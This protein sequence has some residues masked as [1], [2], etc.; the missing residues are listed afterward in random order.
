MS[1]VLFQTLV[2]GSNGK[3]LITTPYFLPDK[4]FRA[5]IRRTIARG[6]S[7][8]AIVPGPGTDQHWVRL[9]SRRLYGELLE[10]GMRIFEYSGSM[11][12]ACQFR[13]P[14]L[15]VKGLPAIRRGWRRARL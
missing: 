4:A 7:I 11:I 12:H 2:E 1:R 3:V 6:V 8:T 5:A 9:A 15:L 13:P 14:T 10:A